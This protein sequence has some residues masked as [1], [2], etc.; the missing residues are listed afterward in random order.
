LD[1]LTPRQIGEAL[2]GLR[3]ILFIESGSPWEN[4]YIESFNGKLREAAARRKEAN[5]WGGLTKP[6]DCCTV[7]APLACPTIIQALQH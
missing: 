2:V 4:G 5:R 7:M 1:T 3:Q 6:G